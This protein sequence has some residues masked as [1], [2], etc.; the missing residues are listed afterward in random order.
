MSEAFERPA[1]WLTPTC[2]YTFG[3]QV[4][5]VSAAA[6]F[7]PDAEQ[8][9]ILDAVFG[10]VGGMPAAREGLIVAP[11]QNL[12]S[13]VL[14][15]IFLGWM[16][17]TCE[18]GAVWS[19]H[20]H[21][22]ARGSFDH[23]RG[24]IEA[25][26]ALRRH[27]ARPPIESKG[28]EAIILR[29]PDGT[30][31]F[32]PFAT[33]SGR[34][35][36]GRSFGKHLH[37]EYLYMQAAHEGA[38]FPTQ[39]TFADWQRIG[40]TSAGLSL[41]DR[42]RA[43]RDRGRPEDA[44][45]EPRFLYFET[46][47]DLPGECELGADCSH[48]YGVTG[49]RY[50]DP[51]RWERANFGVRRG[52]ITLDYISGERRAM[53]AT[54]F[55]RERLGYWDAPDESQAAVFTDEAWSSP[56]LLDPAS[57]IVGEPTFALHVSPSQEWAA[58]MVAG[59][60]ETDRIHVET[61]SQARG[62]LRRYNRRPSTDWVVGWF[63]SRLEGEAAR[64]D[65]MHLVILAGSSAAALLPALAK[66]RG[67]EITVMPASELPAACGFMLGAVS[68]QELVHI[69]DPELTAS[70]LA[71]GRRQVAEKAF[72]WSPRASG[73]DITAAMGATLAAWQVEQHVDYDVLDSIG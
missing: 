31:R 68:R 23:L 59:R 30:E 58:I 49:C 34:G 2:D 48:T 61:T 55:G 46:C 12:K 26:P 24:L 20:Q 39:T 25:T 28:D 70:M 6:G 43:L 40:A 27:L 22:T 32:F 11:R 3:P 64:Y 42:A 35:Y 44:A 7:E 21:Q 60:T 9:A 37:D 67:L 72:V 63:R 50:D 1:Y 53:D 73:G 16:F 18:P 66:I 4:A 33:R 5:E 15:M 38:L 54:Q 10:E 71:V 52:R 14:E 69:G 51:A 62:D 19:A 47:D 45:A 41:S 57:T 8:Q 17:V 29:D 56:D 13:A 65:R 36:R